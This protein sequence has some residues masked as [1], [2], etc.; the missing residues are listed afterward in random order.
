MAAAVAS[1]KSKWPKYE[2][3]KCGGSKIIITDRI[4]FDPI[5]TAVEII[6]TIAQLY[7]DKFK[8]F[9]TNFIDK[10]YGSNKLRLSIESKGNLSGLYGNWDS[11]FSLARE[12][13][14]LY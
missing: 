13:Y 10:L 7:P 6:Y 4:D 2:N 12:K 3:E 14:L 11:Q 9:E 5:I 8:F 1:G